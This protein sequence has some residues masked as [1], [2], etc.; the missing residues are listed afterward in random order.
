MKYGTCPI[1]VTYHKKE[2][3]SSSTQYEDVFDDQ[4]IFSWM[5]RSRLT[6]ESPEVKKIINAGNDGV[7]LYL[8]VKKHD[9][10]GEDFYYMGPVTP[11]R[12]EPKTIRDDNGKE[13]SIVNF[14]LKMEHPV[15]DDIYSYF[16]DEVAL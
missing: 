11:V 2:D 6:L 16:K 14:K 8:F 12:W 9:N 1:F 10:E 15:R 3:I 7:D 13:L 4:R 5:T